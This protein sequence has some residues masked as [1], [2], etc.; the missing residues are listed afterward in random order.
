MT[1][2]VLVGGG[3]FAR[4]LHDWFTPGLAAV[5]DRF[6]GYL[7][8]NDDPMRGTG[9][10]L[11]QLGTIA[12]HRLDPECRLVM[13]V[14]SPLGK[15]KVAQA[16]GFE[17]FASLVHPTAW[18]SASA[19]IGHG[20][21]VAVF[22]DISANA[23]VGAF[24]TV[25]GHASVGH[26]ATLG[27]FSTLSGY[28]DL[29]GHVTVGPGSFLGSGARVLPKVKLGGRCIVGAGAVVVRSVGEDVTLYAAPARRLRA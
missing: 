18:V 27:D 3:A 1:D 4:E 24:A 16:L 26:D 25:N 7:D 8:D 2:Y 13:A 28:V 29:T 10:D 23:V 19:R 17:R 5:G 12:D 20:A 6:T 9:H 11:P 14:A 15:Q 21:V 22:A